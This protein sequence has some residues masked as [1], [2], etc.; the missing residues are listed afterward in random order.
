MVITGCG[1]GK[2]LRQL[3]QEMTLILDMVSKEISPEGYTLSTVTV[4]RD[5]RWSYEEIIHV[6]VASTGQSSITST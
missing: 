3:K 2:K 4:T 6:M 5:Q 1:I